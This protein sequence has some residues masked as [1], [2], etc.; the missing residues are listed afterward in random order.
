M[1][2]TH[3]PQAALRERLEDDYE[4]DRDSID[5][6]ET[7][8]Q[9]SMRRLIRRQCVSL[10]HQGVGED[11][12]MTE[13]DVGDYMRMGLSETDLRAFTTDE[14]KKT[15]ALAE[16]RDTYIPRMVD[17]GR[18]VWQH[19]MLL[20]SQ[21]RG[22]ISEKSAR[23]WMAEIRQGDF[24][25]KIDFVE[26]KLPTYLKKAERLAETREGLLTSAN[27]TLLRESRIK[28]IDVLLD[29]EDFLSASYSTMHRLLREAKAF[30]SEEKEKDDARAVSAEARI[31]KALRS[32][33]ISSETAK[34]WMK[35]LTQRTVSFA[36]TT[37]PHLIAE[38]KL[39]REEFDELHDLASKRKLATID[40]KTF[41]QKNVGSARMYLA[42]LEQDIDEHDEEIAEREKEPKIFG[43]IRKAL[44]TK[45]WKRARS[46][47]EKAGSSDVSPAH[48]ATLRGMN[49]YLETNEAT[50]EELAKQTTPEQDMR[51]MDIA[52]KNAPSAIAKLYGM[53][54]AS[55]EEEL[56]Q[57]MTGVENI[58]T[59]KQRYEIDEKELERKRQTVTTQPI[60]VE[61]EGLNERPTNINA[62]L[63]EDVDTQ[64]QESD[65]AP[66]PTYVHFSEDGCGAVMEDVRERSHSGMYDANVIYAPKGLSLDQII[67]TS[68]DL[69]PVIRRGLAARDKAR[70]ASLA[71]QLN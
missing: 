63:K 20:L 55:G 59:A 26:N 68:R 6:P 45:D 15:E 57:A 69:H 4:D 22:S 35:L 46:H 16:N 24:R 66:K 56:R 41:L 32:G 48:R 70:Q 3:L 65:S 51:D 30:L 18:A 53:A 44:K 37:L 23:Q 8:K 29:K 13:R 1:T 67:E 25:R 42:I 31:D 71:E 40:L 27:K 17:Q 12:I 50:E 9:L 7:R 5:T 47:I 60:H 58:K 54:L 61:K 52:I 33:S 34:E 19:A 28:D 11:S 49:H 10:L 21:F 2:A 39:L 36:M 38:R 43:D 14:E 64:E 62:D